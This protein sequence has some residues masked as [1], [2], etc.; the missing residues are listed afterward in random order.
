MK[1]SIKIALCIFTAA[2]FAAGCGAR[3]DW[4]E[5][6]ADDAGFLVLMPSKDVKVESNT[7]STVAGSINIYMY[8]VSLSKAYYMVAYNQMDFLE[9]AD[10]ADSDKNDILESG[11]EGALNTFPD[12][13]FIYKKNIK[14]NGHPGMEYRAEGTKNKTEMVI[15]GKVFL[16][17]TRLYQVMVTTLKDDAGNP[18]IRK[19][20][21][22]F[23]LI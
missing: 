2:L 8:S 17:G 14:L 19:F 10:L 20:L 12:G 3:A 4:S 6:K 5:Y 22:S 16:V 11:V 13:E 23:K 1:S 21:D 18:N 15:F 9:G 7:A